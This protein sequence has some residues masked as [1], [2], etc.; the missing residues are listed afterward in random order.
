[1][2][3]A[4][5]KLRE[6]PTF[7]VGGARGQMGEFRPYFPPLVTF[8]SGRRAQG[9]GHGTWR[10]EHG[11]WSMERGAWSVEHGAWGMEHGAQGTEHR[12]QGTG[13]GAW[14]M[15]RGAKRGSFVPTF[16]P[17]SHLAQGTGHG[18]WR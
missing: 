7:F 16:L 12:A 9:T 4:Q 8:S 2:E 17:S 10:M 1:M 6:V 3:H 11:A 5:D 18:A 13:H 14:S 15:E